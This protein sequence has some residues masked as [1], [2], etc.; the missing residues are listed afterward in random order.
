MEP[1]RQNNRPIL[2]CFWHNR[3]C[4]MPFARPTTAPFH[5]LISGHADGKL[6]SMAVGYF[7]IQTIAGSTSKGGSDAI[8]KLLRV[9]KQGD[10]AGVTPDGPR[11]PRFSINPTLISLASKANVD[12][13]PMSYSTSRN[14]IFR[15]WDKFFLPLPFSKGVFIYGEPIPMN[16]EQTP[17]DLAKIKDLLRQRLIDISNQ[18]DQICGNK[19]IPE[20]ETNH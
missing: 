14:I 13:A 7:G 5:M 10:C 3:L 15:T 6:I 16:S 12:L 4:M 1:Y 11:G 8:R 17:D 2:V 19:I 20:P 9:L 18:A